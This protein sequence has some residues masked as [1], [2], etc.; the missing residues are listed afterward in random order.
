ME[1]D[2]STTWLKLQVTTLGIEET[3]RMLSCASNFNEH[4]EEFPERVMIQICKLPLSHDNLYHCSHAINAK[5]GGLS[6][7]WHLRDTE[8]DWY[9][10]R[11]YDSEGKS[12]VHS[13]KFFNTFKDAWG[14]KILSLTP[15]GDQDQI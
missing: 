15:I 10:T 11:S 14:L 5:Y 7:E 6:G 13:S 4:M 2:G 9:S 1:V 3:V 12:R 8:E